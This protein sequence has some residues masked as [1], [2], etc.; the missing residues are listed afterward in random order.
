MPTIYGKNGGDTL[1]GSSLND[2]IYGGDGNDSISGGDGN[3][4][5][6][7]GDGN[8]TLD[9]GIGNDTIYGGAGND[10]YIGDEGDDKLFDTS[11]NNFFN[12]GNGNDTVYGDSGSDTIIGGNGNDSIIGWSGDDSISGGDGND[13]LSGGDG[14][15]TLNGGL[16]KDTLYGGLGNDTY[17]IVDS[18]YDIYDSGGEDIAYVST[19]FFRVPTSIEKII[20]TDGAIA[21]PYWINALLPSSIDA[22]GLVQML[23]A[24]KTY[25]FSFPETLPK[26]DTSKDD[27]N[28][29]LKFTTVQKYNTK[30]ALT[31]ISSILDL[32]FI[33]TINPDSLNTITF[34]TNNQ[35]DSGGYAYYPSSSQIGSDL[36]LDDYAA[37]KTLA[38]GT[39][40]AYTLIHELGH[41]LGLKH[42]FP[43][44][45]AGG[46]IGEGPFL[47]GQEDSA[48]FTMLSYST[49]I[50]NYI[51]QFSPLDIAALQYLYGPSKMSRTGDDTY[52][53][54]FTQEP[55][56]I[57]DGG[58]IDTIDATNL[59]VSATI[60]LTPGNWG[61][62]GDSKMPFIISRGQITVNYGT[63]IE[64]VLGSTYN[65][66]LYGNDIGNYIIGNDGND[67]LYGL[68]GNDTINGGSGNDSIDGGIGIDIA[69]FNSN[70]SSNHIIFNKSNLTIRSLSNND[71]IDIL[72]NIERLKFLD[73][74]IAFDL[75][76]NAGVVAKVMGA[77][78]GK[79][80][81]KNSIYFGY[82]LSQTDTG[83]SYADIGQKALDKAGLKTNDQIVS[84]LWKN[85]VGFTASEVEK[86][87]FIK[88]LVD[89]MKPGDLVVLAADTTFNTA[90]I[91]LVG[92]VQTGIEYLPV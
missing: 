44:E 58:G 79:A 62:V 27:A 71:D 28:G 85:V 57:W 24:S 65:D 42:P 9:G 55:N 29:F 2:Y 87:P 66:N 33:E 26:Y 59:I 67:N 75:D 60:Y 11:G 43:T 73:T 34:A 68:E 74:S 86:A 46:G 70:K 22:T 14:N 51:A 31:Y 39:Y 91:N 6:S 53:I 84:T 7:G 30:L 92:L 50:E 89:G 16:G 45:Q 32:K 18:N 63:V 52:I 47:Y 72:K 13:Y 54:S 37:N 49:K 4:Y 69:E 81:I 12:A 10:S 1:H 78:L 15:D 35:T 76:S 41:A 40:G 25:N 48:G 8:D 5:L 36:F 64:N 3:D 88:M 38:G 83:L 23:G 56:F 19:S 77:V 80:S 17:Y 20:Y 61:Y 21:F 90:N 82:W